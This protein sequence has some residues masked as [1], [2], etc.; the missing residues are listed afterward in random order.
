[1]LNIRLLEI[2]VVHWSW[3]CLGAS[4][5]KF[6]GIA[7]LWPR[8]PQP[9]AGLLAR[10]SY[11]TRYIWIARGCHSHMNHECTCSI[12][13]WEEQIQ[14]QTCPCCSNNWHGE[15]NLGVSTKHLAVEIWEE[16]INCD[17]TSL[18]T[19]PCPSSPS[20]DDGS[21]TIQNLWTSSVVDSKLIENKRIFFELVWLWP[22]NTCII[23]MYK[24][25]NHVYIYTYI[26]VLIFIYM[27]HKNLR[28]LLSI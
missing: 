27:Y 16:I 15:K 8:H 5:P 11:H 2:C 19:T 14:Q 17:F 24:H 23:Y 12:L 25:K 9:Y 10:F 4:P 28:Q 3:I 6:W 7:Q 1:M 20:N 26:Y 18:Y 13:N 22:A 21:F